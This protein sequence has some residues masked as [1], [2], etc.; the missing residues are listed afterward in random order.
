[1][2]HQIDVE[3][4]NDYKPIVQYVIDKANRHGVEVLLSAERMVPI[5][6][7][8]DCNGFFQDEPKPKL[9][10]A[11]GQEQDRWIQVLLHESSHMDQWIESSPYWTDGKFCGVEAIDIIELWI[12][13][14]VELTDKK[15]W[16]IIR[17]ARNVELDCERRTA[18]KI[19]NWDLGISAEQYTQ[20]ANAYVLFYNMIGMY[21]Q[22]YSPGKEPYND[23]AI[24]NAMP[25]VFHND[26]W[27]EPA[28]M[29]TQILE[30]LKKC[31]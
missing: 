13:K 17:A 3:I 10:V 14:Y 8:N 15:K 25:K 31:I 23:S 1:M 16:E 19:E 9:A 28:S 24:Y 6:D 30:A 29:S 5:Q 27:Y 21:R 20:R 11:C 26:A 7:G 4:P 22:W 18:L 2:S 12:R